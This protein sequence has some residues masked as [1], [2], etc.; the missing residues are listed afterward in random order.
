M[1][2]NQK[3]PWQRFW[4]PVVKKED[5]SLGVTGLRPLEEIFTYWDPELRKDEVTF[6]AIANTN[7]LLLTGDPGMGK[8]HALEA[9]YITTDQNLKEHG[10]QTL[11]LNLNSYEAGESKRL[12][13]D[14]FENPTYKS[15]QENQYQL[16]VFL[17]SFDECLLSIPKLVQLLINE[18]QKHPLERLYIR[19]ACRPG[20]RL[21]WIVDEF[22]KL[23]GNDKVEIYQ[24][25]PLK[26]S[27][28]IRAAEI[29][30][31]NSQAFWSEVTLRQVTPLAIRPITLKMLLALYKKDKTLP[32]SQF[33]I[34]EKG[35]LLLADETNTGRNLASRT[36]K[37]SVQ[38]R[39]VVAGRIAVITLFTNQRTISWAATDWQSTDVGSLNLYQLAGSSEIIN[40]FELKVTEAEIKEVLSS[41]LF[42]N[43]ETTRLQWAHQTYGEFLAAWYLLVHKQLGPE[44]IMQL[45]TSYSFDGTFQGLVG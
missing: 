27:D 23:Y 45:I 40:G 13:Q 7:C 33:E 24:L 2:F 8:S 43:N 3:Y 16:H 44:R 12:L 5:T 10:H 1:N 35:C 21:S 39:L 42:T 19:I 6:E 9:T 28:V 30:K 26:S 25:A 41:A 4:F 32:N 22:A 15:W 36:D 11:W 29:E 34:Y 18:F 38:Q 14:L 37:L 20:E 17:D 31:I